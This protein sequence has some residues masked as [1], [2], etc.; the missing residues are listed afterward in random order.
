M[1]QSERVDRIDLVL[2]MV[3]SWMSDYISAPHAE[4]GRPGPICPFVA[5]SR[6]N[7]TMEVRIR[8]VGTSPSLQLL[9]EIAR[10]SMREY[11]LISWQGRNPMLRAMVV[12]MPDLE[13]KDTPLLDEAHIRVKDEFVAH[14]LMIGQFHENCTVPAARN[15]DFAVSKSPIPVFAIRSIA[16]HDIFFL[17]ERREWFERYHEKFGRFYTPELTEMDDPVRVK[18]YQEAAEFYGVA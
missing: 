1:S 12:A 17:S 15:D 5:P 9:E 18:K 8:F 11:D 13:S 3:D 10:S 2:T 14:G 6:K 7:R 4:I 16:L